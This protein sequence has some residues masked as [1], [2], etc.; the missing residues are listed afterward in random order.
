MRSVLYKA[1]RETA[2]RLRR[3]LPGPTRV[4]TDTPTTT[5]TNKNKKKK[6]GRRAKPKGNRKWAA[7]GGYGIGAGLG[8]LSGC[9]EEFEGEA[10]D[11]D[12]A[13]SVASGASV[14]SVG[15]GGSPGG[16][17]G[18]LSS[19][20]APPAVPVAVALAG[21]AGDGP[22]PS[23]PAL[24][25]QDADTENDAAGLLEGGDS[26]SDGGGGFGD[27]AAALL[28]HPS[29]STVH[30]LTLQSPSA[31]LEPSATS[32]VTGGDR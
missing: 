25:A 11:G 4:P 1:M 21:V 22:L 2:L 31:P 7:R 5:T 12:D 28:P 9:E 8:W 6:K 10:G 16:S 32:F 3:L 30:P 29:A 24:S 17:A 15:S 20:T 13:G 23:A 26:W 27:G 14:G 19:V 18:G